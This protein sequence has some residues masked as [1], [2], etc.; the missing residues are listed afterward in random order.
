MSDISR[1]VTTKMSDH[2]RR[3]ARDV[4][5][6]EGHASVMRAAA[7]EIDRLTAHDAEVVACCNRTVESA[8][9]QFAHLGMTPGQIE[10][11][12]GWAVRLA[13]VGHPHATEA[14]NVLM[15]ILSTNR[16]TRTDLYVLDH[17]VGISLEPLRPP[18]PD[19]CCGKCPQTMT[20]WD[21]TCLGNPR[22]TKETK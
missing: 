8:R 2:L 16:I 19:Y 10:T 21:C 9:E 14:V 15:Q 12:L 11:A 20:G 3:L 22:C 18:R 7:A 17:R 6:T 1:L 5:Y 13:A 4:A